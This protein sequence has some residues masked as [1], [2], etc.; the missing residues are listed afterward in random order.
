MRVPLM[1]VVKK[2]QATRLAS[3]LAF[4]MITYIRDASTNKFGASRG[5]FGWVLEDNGPMRSVGEAIN[6]E[7]N[8]IYRIYEKP[9]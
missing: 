5:E 4:M 2:M 3:Q 6:G 7:I 9:L 1:G 8:K